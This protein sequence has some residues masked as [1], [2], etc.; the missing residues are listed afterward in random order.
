M[1]QQKA[2]VEDFADNSRAFHGR[3]TAIGR[4]EFGRQLPVTDPTVEQSRVMFRRS[5]FRFKVLR[6]VV[7]V[8]GNQFE[9]VEDSVPLADHH[10]R[11]TDIGRLGVIRKVVEHRQL[12]PFAA[13][14]CHGTVTRAEVATVPVEVEQ[15]KTRHPRLNFDPASSRIPEGSI[16]GRPI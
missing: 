7:G 1:P 8:K 2:I 12:V 10:Q 14:D 13:L 11:Q 4:L 5:V 9:I 16:N 15:P 6:Q 3:P